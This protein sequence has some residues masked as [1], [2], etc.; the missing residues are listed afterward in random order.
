MRPIW[1]VDCESTSLTPDY[2]TG[3]GVIWEL[4]AIRYGEPDDSSARREHLWR[5][6]PEHL[7]RADP[8]ALSVGRYHE[9]TAAMCGTCTLPSRAYDLA[10]D[11]PAVR[12][13][14]PHWSSPEA[15][16]A[17]VARLLDD[18]TIIAAVPSF[19][20]GYLRAWLNHYGQQG[21]WHYRLRDIGSLAYGYLNGRARGAQFLT[22]PGSD[23]ARDH[24]EIPSAVPPLDASTDDFAE[25]LGV[26]PAM[27]LR[28]SALG[29]CRLVAAMLSVIDGSAR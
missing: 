20:A 25:A 22:E 7:E 9:R 18:V 12:H 26:D 24:P 13:D 15:L 5:M 6:K 21:T 8:G 23:A 10:A 1:I 28:H 4:A 16:A 29:D 11:V 27:F 3:A 2:Q 17:D 19:D 14:R